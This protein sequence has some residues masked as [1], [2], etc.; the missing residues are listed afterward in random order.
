MQLTQPCIKPCA[1]Y[2]IHFKHDI[3]KLVNFHT[4]ITSAYFT[5]NATFFNY[6]KIRKHFQIHNIQAHGWSTKG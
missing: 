2:Q 3:P 4:Q 6:L 1:K 5:I